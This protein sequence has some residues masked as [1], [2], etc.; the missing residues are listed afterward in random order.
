M[1][2]QR[3]ALSLAKTFL[4]CVAVVSTAAAIAAVPAHR[5]LAPPVRHEQVDTPADNAQTEPQLTDV[6]EQQGSFSIGDK[7]YVVLLREEILRENS[8]PAASEGAYVVTLTGLE[9][10]DTSG[11]AV[12]EETFPY[13]L[14]DGRFSQ[15]LT[16]SASLLSGEGTRWW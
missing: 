13:V 7:Q 5:L 1:R 2:S 14:A 8:S 16:A 10:L 15:T 4:A 12:Y 11:D 6:A 3:I 9:I